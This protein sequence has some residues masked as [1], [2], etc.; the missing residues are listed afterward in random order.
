MSSILRRKFL[1]KNK[2]TGIKLTS[3]ICI[4]PKKTTNQK[5]CQENTR[6]FE[7]TEII[8]LEITFAENRKYRKNISKDEEMRF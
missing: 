1:T 8:C 6:E 5:A 2:L 3:S 4:V 7:I